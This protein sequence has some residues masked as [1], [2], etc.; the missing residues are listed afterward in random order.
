MT[1]GYHFLNDSG[2]RRADQVRGRERLLLGHDVRQRLPCHVA[3]DDA[4]ARVMGNEIVDDPAR[5]A[6]EYDSLPRGLKIEL[7]LLGVLSEALAFRCSWFSNNKSCR[8][9]NL[10][11]APADSAASAA[12]SA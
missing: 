5:S 1:P 11:C 9:Q 12:S 7:G 8:V 4:R 3:H 6:V 2:M 10:F